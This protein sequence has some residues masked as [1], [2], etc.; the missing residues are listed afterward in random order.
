MLAPLFCVFRTVFGVTYPQ[1]TTLLQEPSPLSHVDFK[2]N[3]DF[4]V[5]RVARDKFQV[6]YTKEVDTAPEDRVRLG[7]FPDSKTPVPCF[8]RVRNVTMLLDGSLICDCGTQESQ[9]LCCCKTMAVIKKYY[10]EW[11]GPSHY[12]ISPRWW[13]YWLKFGHRVGCGQFTSDTEQLLSC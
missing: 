9:G 10:P 2:K 5:T 3:S 13:I 4:N 1:P 6:V 12:D 8:L 11:K 7:S